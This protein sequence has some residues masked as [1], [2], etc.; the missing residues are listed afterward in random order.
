[1]Q[2]A[3]AKGHYRLG[4][5]LTRLRRPAEAVAVLEEG[6]RRAPM[7]DELR[8]AL[9]AA[10]EAQEVARR[11]ALREA[12]EGAPPP[13][14]HHAAAAPPRAPKVDYAAAAAAARGAE[15]IAAAG[16][17]VA[18]GAADGSLPTSAQQFDREW[19]A[20][21]GAP[22]ADRRAWLAR[23]P[24]DRYSDV[25]GESLS[26]ATLASVV[27][28]VDGCLA[29]DGESDDE[30]AAFAAQVLGGLASTKRFE[31]LLMFLGGKEKKAVQ[32]IFDGLRARQRPPPA[33]LA[34][35][36]GIK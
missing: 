2:P 33:A 6:L 21:R 11:A 28:C 27:E 4:T 12:K 19:S 29:A 14:L 35:S 23:L 22:P 17:P 31:M 16:L 13:P 5:A 30:V 3:F 20:L 24:A 8:T 32:R 15:A 18:P 10:R 26:E 25:F 7:N 34:A 36:W 1:M 9:R